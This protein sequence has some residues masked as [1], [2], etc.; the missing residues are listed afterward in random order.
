VPVD[1][2]AVLFANEAFYQAFAARDLA[3][4]EEVWAR[5][6]PVACIHP[7]W[8]PLHGRQAVM[9]SWQGILGNPESPAV[10]CHDA[11]ATIFGD[12]AMV[13]CFEGVPGGFLVATNLFVRQ[14]AVW[15]LVHHQ[16]GPTNGQP[17]EEPAEEGSGR[18]N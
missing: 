8:P 10:A 4:M 2:E 15:K 7:G 14:G 3:A 9:R 1:H 12:S 13:V 5:H 18:P 17:D 16:A 11:R 6:C